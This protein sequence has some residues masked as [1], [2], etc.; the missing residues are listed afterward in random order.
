MFYNLASF[1]LSYSIG[2]LLTNTCLLSLVPDLHLFIAYGSCI[3]HMLL[4]ALGCWSPKEKCKV[5]SNRQSP[6]EALV[7]PDTVLRQRCHRL[8]WS[9]PE[10]FGV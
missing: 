6:P 8:G 7:C 5:K 3:V 1:F 10:A 4:V 2:V 9:C